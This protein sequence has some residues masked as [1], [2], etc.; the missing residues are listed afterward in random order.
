M[1]AVV[2]RCSAWRIIRMS[3][4][5]A[6]L[7]PSTLWQEAELCLH[8]VQGLWGGREIYV[9]LNQVIVRQV[10]R[11]MQE[12]RVVFVDADAAQSLFQLCIENDFLTIEIEARPGLPDEARTTLVLMNNM[13]SEHT[14]AKWAGQKVERFDRLYKAI[15]AL[16]KKVELF[17]A[18]YAGP[19][20]AEG[21]PD[22]LATKE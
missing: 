21:T 17:P 8:D 7:G 12:R 15:L 19:F 1:L 3:L 18:I 11:G 4:T 22:K 20:V 5:A 6:F 13:G 10:S 2:E 16:E 14:L 9:R